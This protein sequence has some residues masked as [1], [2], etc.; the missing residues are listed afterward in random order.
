[1]VTAPNLSSSVVAALLLC[2][3]LVGAPLRAADTIEVASGADAQQLLSEAESLL[4]SN[5]SIAAYELLNER[6]AQLAGNAYYDYLLGVAALDTGRYSD[7]IFSLRRSLSV[8][9]EFSGA[10]MEL[11]RAY[12]ENGNKTLART[13]FVNLLDEQPP[14]GVRG[15]INNYIA[16]IDAKA[17]RPRSR[18]TPFFELAAG[19]D[20][21]ANGSTD[22]QQFLGFTLSPNNLEADS[23]FAEAAAGF[24]WTNPV[25][26]RFGWY[27]GGRAGFRHNSDADFVDAGIVGGQLGMN[28]QRGAFFGRAGIDAYTESRDGDSNSDY[29]GID[30]LLGRR[31]SAAWD[32]SF[33]IRGGALRYDDAIEVL[34]VDRFLYT[35]GATYRFSPLGSFGVEVVGGEDSEKQ[36][37]SPYGN[38]KLGGRIVLFAPVADNGQLYASLGSLTSDYDGLFF[39]AD[40]EDT[41]LSGLLQVEFRN[42]WWDGLSLVP[43]IRYVENDSD[44]TL[45]DYD[46]TVVGLL[47]RWV[48]Q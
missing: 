2:A 5:Q 34:D 33:G 43:R 32:L 28:W 24:R 8:A 25:S 42:V 17:P 13:L 22:D 37:G 47:V 4:A 14:P 29:G 11:A 15:A 12:Y 35:A 20:S 38:S 6:V 44:V 19:H 9:P 40:R 36:D 26:P 41:Q 1:M 45:Y 46:R 16:A 27:A 7:A 21:N 3:L 18:F 31:V 48:P 23:P 39:G 30:V 10:R